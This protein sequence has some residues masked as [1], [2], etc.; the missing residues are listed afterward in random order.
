MVVDDEPNN[1]DVIETLLY[2]EGYVLNYASNGQ[3]ALERLDKFKPDLILLD[4]MMP[5]LNGFEVCQRIKTNPTWQHIP[6]IM[7]TALDSKETLANS[8]EVGAD[9][10]ICKPVS[11]IE[12]KARIRSLLRISQQHLSLIHIYLDR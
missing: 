7:I 11:G 10:F 6:I 4:V 2:T 3:K 9:D 8:L 12:L 5:E 1:F